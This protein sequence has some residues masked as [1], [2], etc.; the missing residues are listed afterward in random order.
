MNEQITALR[1]QV[2]DMSM[3]VK[4]IES[5]SFKVSWNLVP[6]L[7]GGID[8]SDSKDKSVGQ[9]LV[10]K[11]LNESQPSYFDNWQKLNQAFHPDKEESEKKEEGKKKEDKK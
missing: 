6:S 9:D 7:T 2:N 5:K 10:N 1:H 4:T 11:F 3:R 8:L